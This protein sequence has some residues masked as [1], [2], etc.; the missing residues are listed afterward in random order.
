MPRQHD[1][2]YPHLGASL[3]LSPISIGLLFALHIGGA[4][5]ANLP[6]GIAA[7]RVANRGHLLLAT[8][9]GSVSVA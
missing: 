5:I 3:R 7:G 4:A 6:A 1:P 9:S 8:F 2:D